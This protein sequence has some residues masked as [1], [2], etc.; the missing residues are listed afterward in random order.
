MLFAFGFAVVLS[1][2][3]GIY[4]SS[5][6]KAEIKNNRRRIKELEKEISDIRM[7]KAPSSPSVPGVV[8]SEKSSSS[9]FITPGN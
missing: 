3:M 8:Q 1:I 5:G 2:F 7:A 4:S 6:K 9:P